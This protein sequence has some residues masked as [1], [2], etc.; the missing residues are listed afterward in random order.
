MIV[1]GIL[2]STLTAGWKPELLEIFDDI[3]LK[4]DI[5]DPILANDILS[6]LRVALNDYLDD[7][8]KISKVLPKIIKSVLMNFGY[9]Y[10]PTFIEN[11]IA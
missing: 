6:A 7:S 3:L 9:L 5:V 8:E 11:L 10:D 2:T 1:N 4:Y